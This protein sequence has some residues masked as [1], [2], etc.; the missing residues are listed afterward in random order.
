MG[1]ALPCL[2]GWFCSRVKMRTILLFQRDTVVKEKDERG[3]R[4]ERKERRLVS[5]SLMHRK[6]V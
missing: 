2:I 4:R 3:T 6:V 1:Q 5:F